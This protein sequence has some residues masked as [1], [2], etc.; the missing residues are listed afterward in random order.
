VSDA[1]FYKS[2]GLEEAAMLL[3]RPVRLRRRTALSFNQ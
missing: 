3:D 2:L 1:F